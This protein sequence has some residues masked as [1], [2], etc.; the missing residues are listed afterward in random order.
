MTR[1]VSFKGLYM[2]MWDSGSWD[3]GTF[4]DGTRGHHTKFSWVIFVGHG[5]QRGSFNNVEH[6]NTVYA[7]DIT[8]QFKVR[9]KIK[10]RYDCFESFALVEFRID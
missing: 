9:A 1:E 6:S 8:E 5:T 7:N 3:R 4:A 2:L 10:Q